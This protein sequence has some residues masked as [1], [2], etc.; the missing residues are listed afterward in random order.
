VPWSVWVYCLTVI[1]HRSFFRAQL[2]WRQG[3]FALASCRNT[4]DLDV[5]S[6]RCSFCSL[7]IVGVLLKTPRLYGTKCPIK[8]QLLHISAEPTIPRWPATQSRG[9][10]IPVA[11][12]EFVMQPSSDS[13]AFLHHDQVARDHFRHE[14][15]KCRCV[16]PTEG[17]EGLAGIAEKKIDL[18]R[19]KVTRIDLDQASA[20]L[21]IEPAFLDP[22]PLPADRDADL[23]EGALDEFPYGVCL[24][25]RQNIVVG[26]RVAPVIKAIFLTS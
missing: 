10:L 17:L 26:F 9:L 6:P 15:R 2:A 23:G 22:S 24:P 18:R 14:L 5:V 7:V 8:S 3:M 25:G 4:S 12:E 13:T 21:S 16:L 1:R 20:A 19:T 11:A